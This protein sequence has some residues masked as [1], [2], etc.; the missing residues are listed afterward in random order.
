[1]LKKFLRYFL[2]LE[3]LKQYLISEEAFK[4]LEHIAYP[5]PDSNRKWVLAHYAVSDFHL[6]SYPIC[7][8]YLPSAIE[9]Y[10]FIENGNITEN[11]RRNYQDLP[12]NDCLFY[13]KIGKKYLFRYIP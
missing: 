9:N 3:G 10:V 12:C 2:D 13:P 5:L 1:M 4:K 7:K 8:G 6:P 11:P